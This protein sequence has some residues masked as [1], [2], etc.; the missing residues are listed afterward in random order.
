MNDNVQNMIGLSVILALFLSACYFTLGL[1]GRINAALHETSPV[2]SGQKRSVYETLI[3]ARPDRYNGPQAL[4]LASDQMKAGVRIWVDGVPI[5]SVEPL[6][7][8][9]KSIFQSNAGYRAE[10]IRNVNGLLEEVRFAKL[11]PGED[12]L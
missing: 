5:A 9:G 12:D 2:V 11:M 10:Y 6:E 3:Q 8:A 4:V 7:L 1:T